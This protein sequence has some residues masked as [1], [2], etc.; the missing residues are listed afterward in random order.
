[1]A[2]TVT[3]TLETLPWDAFLQ[4]EMLKDR[5]NASTEI[6]EASLKSMRRQID[7]FRQ[8]EWPNIKRDLAMVPYRWE[9]PE[10]LDP[11]WVSPGK[12]V[13]WQQL[14]I[15]NGVTKTDN[16]GHQYR[17]V[18]ETPG[19]WS[20]TDAG[21]PANNP[22][23]IAGYLNNG[24]RFRPPSDTVMEVLQSHVPSDALQAIDKESEPEVPPKY[25]CYRH[26][27]GLDHYGVKTWEAYLQH[28]QAYFE[29]PEYDPPDEMLQRARGFPYFCHIHGFG[30]SNEK[31]ARQHVRLFSSPQWKFLHPKLEDMKQGGQG[32]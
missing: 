26:R 29:L 21:L 15:R 32:A 19:E 12:A 3:P 14:I 4:R 27:T 1:M 28:C 18:E 30:F 25:W 7:G 2:S 17:V 5:S 10:G 13:F 16:D 24:F 23:V 31:R 8:I 9:V 6:Q 22:S 11:H 20:P